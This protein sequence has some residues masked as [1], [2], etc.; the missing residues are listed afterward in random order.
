M[1]SLSVKNTKYQIQYR[2]WSYSCHQRRLSEIN[3]RKNSNDKNYINII[4]SSRR[5]K[6]FNSRRKEIKK[7]EEILS[8]NKKLLNKIV[9]IKSIIVLNNLQ[10]LLNKKKR[11]SNVLRTIKL[12]DKRYLKCQVY[13]QVNSNRED[14]PR[15]SSKTYILDREYLK[16][17]EMS[18]SLKDQLSTITLFSFCERQQQTQNIQSRQYR[19]RQY[20][21][22]N[23]KTQLLNHSKDA[24]RQIVQQLITYINE[25]LFQKNNHFEEEKQFFLMCYDMPILNKLTQL[26]IFN[27]QYKN[28]MKNQGKHSNSH[29]NSSKP[30]SIFKEY[31]AL[32]TEQKLKEKNHFIFLWIETSIIIHLE[33]LHLLKN[34]TIKG[35]LGF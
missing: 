4:E 18:L 20:I 30:D 9:N 21:T 1:Q 25:Q 7:Q 22:S 32:S 24:Q 8:Q 26:I 6:F 33:Y 13:F 35:K 16:K 34:M 5:N 27:V 3:N 14:Q 19:D 23:K 15:F 10:D 17:R 28:E 31:E 12:Q 29:Q 11:I 2:E